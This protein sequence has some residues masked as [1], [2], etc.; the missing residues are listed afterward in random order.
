MRR[1]ANQPIVRAH[2][3]NDVPD[4]Q[5]SVR[6]ARLSKCPRDLYCLWKEYEFGLDG[7]KPAKDYTAVERGQ[8]KYAYSRRKC[9]W[10]VIEKLIRRGYTSDTACDKVYSIYGRNSSVTKVLLAIRKDRQQGG[11]AQLR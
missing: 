2:A 5:D 7:K 10:E 8:C 11:H 4:A 3:R 1:I 6:V 9:F